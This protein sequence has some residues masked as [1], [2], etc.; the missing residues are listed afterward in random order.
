M[1]CQPKLQ[2]RLNSWQSNHVNASFSMLYVNRPCPNNMLHDSTGW[3]DSRDWAKF[4]QM[5]IFPTIIPMNCTS[6]VDITKCNL[7]LYLPRCMPGRS[8]L[9][10]M[11]TG[12]CCR[13]GSGRARPGL[14][15]PLVA[16]LRGGRLGCGGVRGCSHPVSSPSAPRQG[17]HM[18]ELCPAA[19]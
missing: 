15:R 10:P 6:D 18:T 12:R 13:Q 16:A 17:T 19:N 14:L 2:F 3:S 11:R 1:I 5:Q 9:G 7:H 8:L 4:S